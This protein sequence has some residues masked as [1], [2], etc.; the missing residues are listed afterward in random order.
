[1]VTEWFDE[2]KDDVTHLP[3]EISKWR[4]GQ[5]CAP[6]SLKRQVRGQFL[7]GRRFIA[8]EEI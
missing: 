8:P 6:P 3:W 4:D 7:E 5:R 2:Y 1:M